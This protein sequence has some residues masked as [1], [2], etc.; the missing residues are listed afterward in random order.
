M[1]ASV[2]R[3]SRGPAKRQTTTES[4][5]SFT[6]MAPLNGV[7]SCLMVGA[8]CSEDEDPVC[9]GKMPDGFDTASAKEVQARLRPLIRKTQ[10]YT[11]KTAHRGVWV[12]P[13]AVGRDRISR[14]VRRG[15]GAASVL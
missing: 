10:P 9:S 8:M 14:E 13:R 4:I 7:G 11:K 6:L 1:I 3:L 2:T 12:E 15:K 5:R